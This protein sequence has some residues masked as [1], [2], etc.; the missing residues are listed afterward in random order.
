MDPETEKIIKEQMEKLPIEIRNLFTDPGLGD[1]ILNIGKKNGIVNIEQLGI[2]QTETNLMLLGLVHP[3]DY[4]NELKNQLKIDDIKVDN[5]V[6]D[7]NAQILS[8]IREKLKEVYEKTD[9]IGDGID[10]QP[11]ESREEILKTIPARNAYSTPA[12]NALRSNV[13][14]ADA[15][16]ETPDLSAEKELP[17]P[18]TEEKAPSI[19]TQKFSGA[20]QIPTVETDHSLNNMSKDSGEEKTK[21]PKVDP[22]RMPI[23]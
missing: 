5:I 15:G 2:F 8:G 22:Y 4:P 13:G 21:L 6:N 1:K 23:D 14:W 20:F 17:A 16:G 3:D 12:S 9:K 11:L 10:E 18:P 7:V 19:L